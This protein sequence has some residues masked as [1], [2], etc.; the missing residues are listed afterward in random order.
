M[1]ID[2]RG[3]AQFVDRGGKEA[4]GFQKLQKHSNLISMLAID[5]R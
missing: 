5:D 3:E 4:K 1:K 2:D